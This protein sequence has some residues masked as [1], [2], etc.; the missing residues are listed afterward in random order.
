MDKIDKSDSKIDMM[1]DAAES[2]N[3][4][5]DTENKNFYNEVLDGGVDQKLLPIT[6][7]L[8]RKEF[9]DQQETSDTS[10]LQEKITGLVDSVFSG[11]SSVSNAITKGLTTMA[12]ACL[13]NASMSYKKEVGYTVSLGVLGGIQ[14]VDYMLTTRSFT[15][16]TWQENMKTVV[17]GVMVLS[18]VDSSK[19]EKNDISVLV[20]NCFKE[21]SAKVQNALRKLL[22]IETNSVLTPAQ[23]RE[24][25]IPIYQGL[26][27]LFKESEE[28]WIKDEA[29][30]K[31]QREA[32]EIKIKELREKH[33]QP[34][35]SQGPMKG[36]KKSWSKDG[37]LVP[38]DM[39]TE[40][41]MIILKELININKSELNDEKK[42]K[43][44][45]DL[46]SKHPTCLVFEEKFRTDMKGANSTKLLK[47]V[48]L[49]FLN[50]INK[51]SVWNKSKNN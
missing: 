20:Q 31:E 41:A 24:K 37:P 32:D 21:S 39:T 47:E 2:L 38:F 15:S 8:R 23:K 4:E 17:S 3:Q 22:L 14:R 27:D 28:I 26:P 35:Q 5:I 36:W 13:N 40:G 50:E 10:K 48:C 9:I 29:K 33:S 1:K 30:R 51:K 11:S 25:T 19:V 16:K 45:F 12:T 34:P 42:S 18:S 6:C 49:V 7:V 43:A 44:V 46:Y